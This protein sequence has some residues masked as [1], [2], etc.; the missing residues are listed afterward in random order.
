M[1][2]PILAH[3]GPIVNESTTHIRTAAKSRPPILLS[4][5]RPPQ[6]SVAELEKVDPE[7]WANRRDL[8]E[9]VVH[10]VM[11]AEMTWGRESSH[12]AVFRRL[13][14]AKQNGSFAG[15]ISVV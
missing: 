2:A 9:E 11:D 8:L 3:S 4:I 6:E 7:R 1:I 10:R 14:H 5:I 13:W 12:V 15:I